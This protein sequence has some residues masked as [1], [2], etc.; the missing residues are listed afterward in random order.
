M[1]TL[2]KNDGLY[3][4]IL[5]LL[6][7][8]LLINLGLMPV[9]ADEATR[10][11]VALEMKYSGNYLTPTI[12]GELYFNKPPLYNWI[13]AGVFKLTGS[14]SEFILRIPTIFFLLLFGI[15]IFLS[16]RKHTNERTAAL[17]AFAFITAGRVMFYDSM[18]GLIDTSFSML[19]FLNFIIIYHIFNEK[20]RVWMFVLSYFLV[21]VTFLMKGLPS[22]VFQFLTLIAAGAVF[23]DW[24]K[25]FNLFHALGIIL[26]LVI[27]GGYYFLISHQYSPTDYIQVLFSESAKRTFLEHGWRSTFINLFT[28]PFEQVYHLLPWSLMV[29]F[30]FQKNFYAGVLE[31]KFLSYL[32]LVFLANIPVYWISVE[33]Y[34]RYM[35]M[36]YPIPFI[37]WF[38]HFSAIGEERKEKR[39]LLQAFFALLIFCIPTIIIGNFIYP[40][41][42]KNKVFIISLLLVVF[43]GILIW[44]HLR[45][46]GF[47]P[48]ILI[49][50][51]LILRL[52]FNLAII[53]ER[54]ATSPTVHQKEQSLQVANLTEG[55]NLS[56]WPWSG[57]S[58]ETIYYLTRET[59]KIIPI[60]QGEPIPGDLYI[61]ADKEELKDWEE[62]LYKFQT[63]W[64]NRML[65]LSKCI[66]NK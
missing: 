39:I 49:I 16:V 46:K 55:K 60:H 48:E 34:P 64:N 11:I 20:N 17:S 19:I 9:S 62:V 61:L 12:N 3:L 29:I 35:F 27:A 25:F 51:I 41:Q 26:F 30:F 43:L 52:G 58:H 66:E 7:P 8:A 23:K 53:P 44:F 2:I 15:I 33:D 32:G 36:L 14:A 6:F 50:A 59:G 54:Y 40:F 21:A 5:I 22:I 37:I 57:C 38:N 13:L 1:K 31:N 47:L 63:R 56:L 65:R 45:K 42:Q 4:A 18:L 10:A 28:F 24:K